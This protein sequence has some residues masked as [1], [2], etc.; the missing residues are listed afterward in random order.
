M[1]GGNPTPY[2]ILALWA[3]NG[4]SI[5]YWDLFFIFNCCLEWMS[6]SK[7]LL[8]ILQSRSLPREENLCLVWNQKVFP[9][10]L[11]PWELYMSLTMGYA[12]MVLVVCLGGHIG[13]LLPYSRAAIGGFQ[14]NLFN[15]K[16]I[17]RNYA[18]LFTLGCPHQHLG[19]SKG[20]DLQPSD[21]C[22]I[23]IFFGLI[24]LLK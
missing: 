10:S 13:G 14:K 23:R 22:F 2:V 24:K 6:L 21:I 16:E 7:G 20:E 9:L 15:P 18:F 12:W 8:A 5:V 1:V 3:V 11:F 19:W 4:L 17:W